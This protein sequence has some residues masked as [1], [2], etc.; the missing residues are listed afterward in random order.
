MSA[1]PPLVHRLLAERTW[2]YQLARYC[3]IGGFTFLVDFSSFALMLHAHWPLTLVATLSYG[4]GTVVHFSCNKYLNFRA[5]DRPVRQQV[6]TYAI[7]VVFCWLTTVAIVDGMV[8]LGLQPLV[9]KVIAVA[10]NV[11]IGFLGHRHLTFGP[12]IAAVVQRIF[13]R[14]VS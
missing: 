11:P 12:G 7:V 13:A 3:S 8:A 4:L 1:L 6:V 2:P 9:A 14:R 5:H 10:V